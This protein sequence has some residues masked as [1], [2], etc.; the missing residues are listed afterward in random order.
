MF[1]VALIPQDVQPREALFW[2]ACV[3]ALSLG[4]VPVV[5]AIW[6]PRDLFLANHLLVLAPIY[7]LLLDLL[8]KV[9]DLD[10]ILRQDA[11]LA[12]VAIGL[13]AGGVWLGLLGKP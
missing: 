10:G 12:F 5:A 2:P 6:N 1:A 8:Q 4:L 11:T 3:M 9:Y 13:F 7:W